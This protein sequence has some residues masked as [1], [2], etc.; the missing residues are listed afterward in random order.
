LRLTSPFY[1]SLF[2]VS[3]FIL[4]L[5]AMAIASND[6]MFI[7]EII[8]TPFVFAVGLF[9]GFIINFLSKKTSNIEIL[10]NLLLSS[11]LS[12]VILNWFFPYPLYGIFGYITN[13][14]W[15]FPYAIFNLF[16][17]IVSSKA[18]F[19]LSFLEENGA[20]LLVIIFYILISF[21]FKCTKGILDKLKYGSH[22]KA[23]LKN[24]EIKLDNTE[25]QPLNNLV[26]GTIITAVLLITF[27]FIFEDIPIWDFF[28][29]FNMFFFLF[30]NKRTAAQLS[31]VSI[32][33]LIILLFIT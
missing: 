8:F 14:F 19:N 9:F 30:F 15:S 13:I 2:W 22:K 26:L 27:V 25:V 7:I 1:F 29:Y 18:N 24:T 6:P 33:T 32:V 31:L 28:I 16:E 5:F 10:F 23:S 3:S 17:F 4:T 11:V 21:I 12:I 20:G